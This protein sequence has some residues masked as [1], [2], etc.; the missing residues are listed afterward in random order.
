MHRH[1]YAELFWVENGHGFHLINQEKVPLAPGHL[2]MIRPDDTHSFSSQSGI[3]IMNLAFP[4]QTLH[5]FEKRYFAGGLSYFWSKDP[6]PYQT[7]LNTPESRMLSRR[8]A[9]LWQFRNSL[10]YLDSFLLMVFRSIEE[11][12]NITAGDS[13]PQWL[14][15]AIQHFSTPELFRQGPAGFADLCQKNVDH[16]NRVIRK[17][18]H[19]TLS[20][21]VTEL[22]MNFAAK[23]L[24]LTNVPI[25]I[26]CHDCGLS[27]LGHFYATFKRV[28]QQTPAE[29]RASSQT[30]V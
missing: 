28:Y 23:Q 1:D 25:K 11:K 6:L 2:V 10:L 21:L 4:L 20:A 26:I 7:I 8:A 3:T 30:I 18:L 12:N 29:Y 19:K 22:R 16:V 14:H 15:N 17:C 13:V 9:E 5:F 27:N 24:S